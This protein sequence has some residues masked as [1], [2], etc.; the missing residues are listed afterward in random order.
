MTVF[1]GNVVVQ[2]LGAAT[3]DI[4]TVNFSYKNLLIKTF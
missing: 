2:S 3:I 1:I 4:T